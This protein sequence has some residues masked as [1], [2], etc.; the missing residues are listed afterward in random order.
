MKDLYPAQQKMLNEKATFD[1]ESPAIPCGLMAK[2]F[3]NDTLTFYKNFIDGKNPKEDDKI[4]LNTSDIAWTTDVGK[5]NNIKDL[6]KDVKSYKDIQWQDM[7]DPRFIVWMRNAGLPN[8]R[9]LYGVID[10]DIKAGT[11]TL[12]VDAQ[13]NVAPFEGNKQF[14]LS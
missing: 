11:Y 14:V 8:F 1:P 5:F 7:E 3:F 12:K 6:P 2:S 10:E 13:Y 9:K 4:E